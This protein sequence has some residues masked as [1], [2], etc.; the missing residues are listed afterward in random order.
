[1]QTTHGDIKLRLYDDTPLHRDNFIKLT[2]SGIYEGI[3]F[4]RVINSFMIQAGDPLTRQAGLPSGSDTLLTYTVPAEFNSL[5]FHKKGAL[6][7]ARQ[8]NEVNPEMRSSGTQFYIVQ[9]TVQTDAGL[10]LEEQRINNGIRQAMFVRFIRQV[11]DSAV[12]AGL[13][14]DAGEIH[15]KASSLMFEYLTTNGNYVISD[16]QRAVYKTAGGV[17]RLDGTY[18]VFG[19]VTEGLDVVD[20][21]AAVKTDTHDRPLTDVRILKMKII[22]K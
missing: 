17:P 9:G 16:E 12:K 15:E 5:H 19:E 20:R 11:A 14:P 4:H 6:A 1:M 2:Q 3:S 10:D 7:A 22:S 13:S 18:T 21:I 8:G